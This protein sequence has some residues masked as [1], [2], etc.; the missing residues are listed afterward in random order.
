MDFL[1]AKETGCFPDICVNVKS[2]TA[3]ERFCKIYYKYTTIVL[4]TLARCN[5]L[6]K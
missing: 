5:C 4:L 3:I 6:V 1:S 2:T